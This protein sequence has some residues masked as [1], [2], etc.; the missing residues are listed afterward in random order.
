MTELVAAT[1][2][3][4][5]CGG[6]RDAVAGIVD[7]WCG[8]KRLVVVGYGMVA[9]RFLEALHARADHGWHVT[10]LAEERPQRL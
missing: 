10:V 9:Q 6:C 4:T 2:A 8:V 7:C 3:T 1:R 5:G